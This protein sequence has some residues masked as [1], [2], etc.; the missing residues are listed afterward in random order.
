MRSILFTGFPGFLGSELLPRVVLR[1]PGSTATCLVQRKY[2]RLAKNRLEQIGLA[3]PDLPARVQLVEADI[4]LEDLGLG[5][6]RVEFARKTTEIYHLAAIYDLAVR[7][8]LAFRVNVFGTRHVLAFTD[9]CP[10]L[11]RFHYMSTCYV[12]GR[13]PGLFGEEDLG[14]GQEFHNS[15]EETKF[16]AEVD[17]QQRMQQGLPATVYRPSI[18][19]GDSHTGETQKYDGP[20]P[21]IRWML[22]QPRFAV[23]PVFGNPRQVRLNFVPRDFVVDAIAHLSGLPHAIGRVYQLAD[24]SPPTVW[25]VL[26]ALAEAAGKRLVR[27]PIPEAVARWALTELPGL[28]RVVGIPAESLDYF[29]HPTH[30][31]TFHT[32]ADLEGTDVRVPRFSSYVDRLV[33]YV[34]DH[35]EIASGAMA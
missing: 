13:Y 34:R 3:H 10:A 28:Q 9:S 14:K 4:A 16:L 35:P 20:Y 15:Y 31:T 8:E 33:E 5:D 21:T 18:V 2:A 30:Y 7:R 29:V 32:Q 27:V 17:V 25:D 12:S 22:R 23:L 26:D 11:T 19:V 1:T 6:R 24:P